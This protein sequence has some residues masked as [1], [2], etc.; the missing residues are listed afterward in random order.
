MVITFVMQFMDGPVQGTFNWT[1][2]GV[3]RE[4]DSS[5]TDSHQ[6]GKPAQSHMRDF[7]G[8]SSCSTQGSHE[9]T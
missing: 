6:D 1:I 3:I 4:K 5:A 9:R 2:L 7:G 8:L